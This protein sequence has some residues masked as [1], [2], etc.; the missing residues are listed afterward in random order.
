MKPSSFCR[1]KLCL[2][3]PKPFLSRAREEESIEEFSIEAASRH[4][5]EGAQITKCPCALQPDF[6]RSIL[7]DQFRGRVAVGHPT[8]QTECRQTRAATI[9]ENS[10]E[11]NVFRWGPETPS[12]TARA[13]ARGRERNRSGIVIVDDQGAV[14]AVLSPEISREAL[15]IGAIFLAHP[16]ELDAREAVARLSVE[17]RRTPNDAAES[18]HGRGFGVDMDLESEVRTE[19][20]LGLRNQPKATEAQIT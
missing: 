12:G 10:R 2:I 6:N 13:E 9:S 15:E 8:V 18:Q 3:K 16:E 17:V 4:E 7:I 20:N 14:C 5:S 11:S 19:I 1:D